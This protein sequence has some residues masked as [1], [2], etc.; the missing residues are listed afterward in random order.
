MKNLLKGEFFIL[1]KRKMKLLLIPILLFVY[2]IG[3][4]FALNVNTDYKNT[5][6]KNY[7]SV[8]G[9]IF[10]QREADNCTL[11]NFINPEL[12]T[13]C[14]KEF[15]SERQ[16]LD[17]QKRLPLNESLVSY[18]NKR[19]AGLYERDEE[20]YFVNH[21][22]VIETAQSLE[23]AGFT[24]AYYSVNGLSY[25]KDNFKLEAEVTMIEKMLE[26]KIDLQISPFEINATNYLRIFLGNGGIIVFIAVLALFNLDFFMDDES[27]SVNNVIYSQP[28]PRLHINS[29]KLFTSFIYSTVSILICLAL[30]SIILANLFGL[31]SLNTL[32]IVREN[33]FSFSQSNLIG[34]LSI[35]SQLIYTGLIATLLLIVALMI[36]QLTIMWTKNTGLGLFLLYILLSVRF[37]FGSFFENLLKY[38]PIAYDNLHFVFFNNYNMFYGLI[39][40]FLSSVFLV[41]TTLYIGNKNDIKGGD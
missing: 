12:A 15:F 25:P 41:S 34:V 36:V 17:A 10:A 26:S 28:Y 2:I 37:I 39:T 35:G 6:D 9:L 31:G 8:Y 38:Y 29:A 5:L 22:K 3:V 13:S 27:Q 11:G 19:Q 7:Y 21:L 32:M 1:R 16:I 4:F 40:L 14:G 18:L 30:G 23:S 33:I 20:K 24:S